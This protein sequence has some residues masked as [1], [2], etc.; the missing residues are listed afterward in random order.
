MNNKEKRINRFLFAAFIVIAVVLSMCFFHVVRADDVENYEVEEISGGLRITKYNGIKEDIIVPSKI[1][2]KKVLQIGDYAFEENTLIKSIVIP[3]GI[4]EIGTGA[5]K[6][7]KNISD[8]TIPVD[9]KYNGNYY[10]NYPTFYG[11]NGIEKIT[12]TKGKTGIMPD[13][14]PESGTDARTDTDHY[15]YGSCLEYASDGYSTSYYR[16][17][18]KEVVF[19]EGIT[20][21]GDYAFAT[22]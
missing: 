16:S 3:D 1:N 2:G 10:N 20:H 9:I 12:Y 13:R 7:C 17:V 21:I 19:E 5:F 14:L 15:Y 18:L 8:I 11:C 22:S 6:N 4:L